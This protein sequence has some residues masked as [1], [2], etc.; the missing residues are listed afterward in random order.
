VANGDGWSALLALQRA[1]HVTLEAVTEEIAGLKLGAAETNV[2]ANLAVGGGR[3][4]SELSAAVG[5]RATTMTSVLD[6]L[7]RRGLIAR[8]PVPHDRRAI[9]IELTPDGRRAATAVRRAFRRV[10][11]RALGDLPAQTLSALREALDAL[12][13]VQ[14]DKG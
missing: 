2:L 4:I 8:S 3:T 5:S 9:R 7:E 1:T 6:R 14:H 10:E 12:T 13:G 11:K